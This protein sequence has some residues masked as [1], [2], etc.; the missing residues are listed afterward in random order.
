MC[1]KHNF[2]ILFI[3]INFLFLFFSC[4]PN[5]SETE[6]PLTVQV[7]S[8]NCSIRGV[9]DGTITIEIIGGNQPY[10]F[11]WSNGETTKDIGGLNAGTYSITVSDL[12]NSSI[13]KE[14]NIIE[15]SES[16]ALPEETVTNSIGMS[17][18]LIRG[19][20]TKMGASSGRGD[21]KPVHR[22]NLT[23]F[24][25]GKFEVS[26]DQFFQITGKRPSIY[27]NNSCPVTDITW[28]EAFNFCQDLS[29]LENRTYRLPTEAEWEYAASST[30]YG[31]NYPWGNSITPQIEG[32]KFENVADESF[33]AVFDSL[34]DN[35]GTYFI[36]YDDGFSHTSPIGSFKPNS[37]GL[38]DTGGN[39]SEW[40]SDL[41]RMNS[42]SIS[43]LN[44]P[45]GP[46]TGEGRCIRGGSY[47]NST[48]YALV[49]ARIRNSENTK[50]SYVGFR[51]VLELE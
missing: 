35:I 41:Y 49:R 36:G 25:I 40:C 30:V 28:N 16:G 2:Y 7:S 48:L 9:S 43:E 34:F 37:I 19:G 18:K 1:F 29:T 4:D 3:L 39:V 15:P 13:S 27:Q 14:V 10:K 20:S 6:I 33:M 23:S 5:D 47:G 8:T 46:T 50:V 26:Q 51:V 22:V 24:Y 32:V 12:D 31:F 21:E 45:Q 42:Y 17:F 44:N 11:I 38:Y